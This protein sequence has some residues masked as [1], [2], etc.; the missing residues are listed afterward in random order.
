VTA[1]YT[2]ARPPDDEGVYHVRV[3]RLE[4]VVAVAS[5]PVG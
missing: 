1:A 2:A 4:V 5:A 3:V